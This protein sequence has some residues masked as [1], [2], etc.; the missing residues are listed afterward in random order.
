[1]KILVVDDDRTTRK[2]LS[3]YL[4]SRGFE[5]VTAENGLDALQKLGVEQVHLVVTDLNMPFMD[6]I[7]FL[8][9]YK[10]DP[11]VAHIPALM[12]TTEKDEEERR[13]AMEAGAAAYLC[14]PVT[15]EDVAAAIRR[16]L[17]GLFGKGVGTECSTTR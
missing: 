15:A 12:V 8:R 6:G 14:K 13:R 2:L 16:I 3:F 17:A 9:T 1:M 11:Q 10:A 5:T 7:E 4:K